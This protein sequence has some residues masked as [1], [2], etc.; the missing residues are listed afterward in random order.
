LSFLFQFQG[1]EIE[2]HQLTVI[3]CVVVVDANAEDAAASPSTYSARVMDTSQLI[4]AIVA[5]MVFILLLCITV[6]IVLLKRTMN[7]FQRGSSK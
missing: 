6:I 7:Q 2:F 5:P 1:F 3:H 4:A